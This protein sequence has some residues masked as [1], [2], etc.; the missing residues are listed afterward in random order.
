MLTIA[1][2]A[3]A[4]VVLAASAQ[5]GVDA[6]LR[7]LAPCA[8]LVGL[9]WAAYWRP[10]I[11]IADD[12][13]VVRNVFSTDRVRLEQIQRIDTRYALTLETTAGKVTAWAAPA[14][15]RHS[16]VFA[17]RG[18]G[19]GLPEST[20]LAGTIRPGDLVTS[21]SGAAAAE[22]RRRWERLRDAR[23]SIGDGPAEP[24]DRTAHTAT[25]LVHAAL[26]VASIASIAL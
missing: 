20:Y 9:T 2:A 16:V 10:Q 18:D 11:V 5:V 8:L 25:I 12:A 24:R 19:Q 13:V 3:V 22:I 14:P 26:L 1:V 15:G 17:K 21:D 6:L 7:A 23:G 4:S